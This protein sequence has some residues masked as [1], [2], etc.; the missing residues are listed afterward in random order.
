MGITAVQRVTVLDLISKLIYAQIEESYQVIYTETRLKSVL[1][2]YYEH[3]HHIR[4]QWVEGLTH[5][6]HHYLNSTN[7][8]L[9]AIKPKD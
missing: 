6:S 7:N 2:Y 9:E 3:W 1:N 4:D 8:R 5:N